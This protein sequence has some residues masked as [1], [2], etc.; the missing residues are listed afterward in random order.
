M[1]PHIPLILMGM[2]L[3]KTSHSFASKKRGLAM[4]TYGKRPMARDL[5]QETYGK[6]PMARDLR[7]RYCYTCTKCYTRAKPAQQR[8]MKR[9]PSGDTYQPIKRDA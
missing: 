1:L 9:D 3:K 6:R 7:Q 2:I 4:K 5:W 8:R